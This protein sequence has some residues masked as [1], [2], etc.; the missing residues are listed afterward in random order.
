MATATLHV[1]NDE[2]SNG[3]MQPTSRMMN[4]FEIT[5]IGSIPKKIINLMASSISEHFMTTVSF[6]LFQNTERWM[7]QDNIMQYMLGKLIK[8][9][10]PKNVT[11]MP[12][13]M[14]DI[15]N[16]DSVQIKIMEIRGSTFLIPTKHHG[17]ILIQIHQNLQAMSSP[18]SYINNYQ[19]TFIGGRHQKLAFRFRKK[20]HG[21]ERAILS[22][23][24][25]VLTI[26]IADIFGGIDAYY[27]IPKRKLD[28][29]FYEKGLK[30]K[31]TETIR[32]FR[33]ESTH[34]YYNEIQE[35]WHFN[36]LFYGK[37]GT[38][39]NSL[40]NAL[41]VEYD[42][43]V[44]NITSALA[45]ISQDQY[46]K[47]SNSSTQLIAAFSGYRNTIFVVDEIDTIFKNRDLDSNDTT[48]NP[49]FTEFLT[50]LDCLSNGNI[51]M[52]STNH[53]DRLDPA[54]IRSG[55]FNQRIEMKYWTEETLNEALTYHHLKKE[56]LIPVI[57]EIM[58]ED[59]YIPARIMDAIRQIHLEKIL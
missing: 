15:D 39:K 44:L 48:T 22:R 26:N 28:S 11:E 3:T 49:L 24:Q 34:S 58:N 21:I 5:D 7:Y 27:E 14:F 52:A 18:T 56:D 17:L 45:R 43:M 20:Y 55:R 30:E 29:V 31:I 13:W 40:I 42:M 51:L 8:P 19:I 33:K 41:A 46:V 53:I 36:I 23:V 10:Y 9:Y 16:K 1:T 57:P 6:V 50:F 47:S 4:G 35:P 25:N 38:G 54:L 59:R 2:S 12:K 32:L 37:P